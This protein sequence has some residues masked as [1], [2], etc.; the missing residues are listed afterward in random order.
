MSITLIR[1]GTII[2]PANRAKRYVGDLWIEGSRVVPAAPDRSADKVIDATGW[3][4]MPGGVDM[5]SHFA[6]PKTA[7][8][9]QLLARTA[10]TSSDLSRDLQ[11]NGPA[12]VP[13]IFRTGV[14]YAGLGYTT[15][16]DAA[17]PPHACESARREIARMPVVDGHFLLLAGNQREMLE[18]IARNDIDSLAETVRDLYQSHGAAGIKLVSPGDVNDWKSG[19]RTRIN[20]IDQPLRTSPNTPRS[21][22]GALARAVD[23]AHLPHPLHIH[24]NALGMPG[25]WLTTLATMQAL[26]DSRGHFAHVQFHSYRGAD[27][28]AAFGSAVA[29][30]VEYIDTH[31]N[32]TVD[33]GQVMFGAAMAMTGDSPLAWY[34]QKSGA[35]SWISHDTW[36]E[37]GCGVLPIRYRN[38]N[39]IHALQWAIGLEWLLRLKNPWQ[40][41]LSTDHPNGASFLA[42]PEIIGLLMD[43]G[44]RR[45]RLASLHADVHRDAGL[46]ELDR[47]YTLEEIAIITRAAPARILGL[48]DKGHLGPGAVADIAIYAPQDTWV[49]TFRFPRMVF[50][51]GQVV[52]DD[53]EPL[54]FSPPAD[55][56]ARLIDLRKSGKQRV[57][58]EGR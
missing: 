2:D 21:I 36:N 1:N 49:S 16:V 22:L 10:L 28:E 52:I 3:Y 31:S 58:D 9:R 24:C 45:E 50:K 19:W 25:N 27:S 17:I 46:S 33:I 4:V 48:A 37:G 53:G 11:G 47:E 12:F 6:G 43:A 39:R 42:Y 18:T 40:A 44:S 55:S 26:G 38:R 30:L 14:C 8:A 54:N 34:L 13:D 20:D 5:H 15:A 56:R 35:R 32:L 57:A 7:F 51:S 41:A 23:A 29:P